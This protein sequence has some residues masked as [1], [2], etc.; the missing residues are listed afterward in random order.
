MFYF[1]LLKPYKTSLTPFLL[2]RIV[3][4]LDYIDFSRVKHFLFRGCGFRSSQSL[5]PLTFE[6]SIVFLLINNVVV[7]WST[8]FNRLAEDF[9]KGVLSFSSV[10]FSCSVMSDSLWPHGLQHTRLPCPSPTPGASSNSCPLSRW[11]HPTISSSIVPFS[12]CLQSFQASGPFLVSQY[13]AS[14]GQSIGVSAS[15]SV[16]PVNIQDWFS[17]GWTGW[18]SLQSKR[19]S[20]VFSNTTIQKH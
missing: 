10:Q 14:G 4:C 11:G 3:S 20:R 15:A 7:K 2:V 5:L 13:F 18:I 1:C 6:Y 16:L 17:L 19:Q 8:D 12:S 9:W